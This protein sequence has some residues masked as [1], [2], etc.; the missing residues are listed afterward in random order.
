MDCAFGLIQLLQLQLE[1]V[2]W[3][4]GVIQLK[5]KILAN[6]HQKDAYGIQLQRLVVYTHVIHTKHKQMD[7]NIFIHGTWRSSTSVQQKMEN[8]LPL[9]LLH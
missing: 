7:A 8:V 5:M 9:M 6:R 4:L 2:L 1:S 3:W